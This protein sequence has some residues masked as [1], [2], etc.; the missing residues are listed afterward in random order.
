MQLLEFYMVTWLELVADSTDGVSFDNPNYSKL[1]FIQF[2]GHNSD[3][4][5]FVW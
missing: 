5:F 2:T 4:A 3:A 1:K